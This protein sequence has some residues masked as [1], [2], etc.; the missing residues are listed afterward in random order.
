M[1]VEHI[2]LHIFCAGGGN[3]G[4]T[5]MT[6]MTLGYFC[7]SVTTPNIM[8]RSTIVFDTV[9]NPDISDPYL[10]ELGSV[11]PTLGGQDSKQ[12]NKPPEDVLIVRTR[13]W[14]AIGDVISD[15]ISQHDKPKNLAVLVDTDGDV[16]TEDLSIFL[17]KTDFTDVFINCILWFIW[18]DNSLHSSTYIREVRAF[19][20]QLCPQFRNRSGRNLVSLQVFNPLTKIIDDEDGIHTAGGINIGGWTIR[21]PQISEQTPVRNFNRYLL[22]TIPEGPDGFILFEQFLEFVENTIVLGRILAP[23]TEPHMKL[24]ILGEALLDFVV[25]ETGSR[26]C[27][28]FCIPYISPEVVYLKT[29]EYA[30]EIFQENI[31]SVMRGNSVSVAV[32]I[33]RKKRELFGHV[34]VSLER[35]LNDLYENLAKVADGS[36][37]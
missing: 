21:K 29:E 24:E 3:S 2:D 28:V 37:Y 26:Y 20:K 35:N 25:P 12:Y 15:Y 27:N 13:D 8:Q 33:N 18:T 11:G 7:E 23:Q 17:A 16:D 4:K 32:A 5:L 1:S 30:R 36:C 6:L 22:K 14:K 10:G 9:V 31:R 19:F 34:F